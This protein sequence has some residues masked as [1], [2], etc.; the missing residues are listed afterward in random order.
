MEK[1]IQK[2]QKIFYG[3]PTFARG[4]SRSGYFSLNES[5]QLE[6][7][8]DTLQQLANGTRAPNNAVEQVFINEVNDDIECTLY[9]SRLWKKYQA[10][11]VKN[12]TFHSFSKSSL[13]SSSSVDFSEGAGIEDIDD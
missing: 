8:G 7:Y 11:I 2:G 6:A 1:E 5:K 4:L 12:K 10:A 13:S 9:A 3:D